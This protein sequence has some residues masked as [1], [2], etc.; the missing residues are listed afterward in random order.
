MSK[1][2]ANIHLP[3]YA[4]RAAKVLQDVLPIYKDGK[5]VKSIIGY[6]TDTYDPDTIL[7]LTACGKIVPKK[8]TL[9]NSTLNMSQTTCERCSDY[10]MEQRATNNSLASFT[11]NPAS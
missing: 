4:W 6:Y 2:I 8:Q 7:V 11:A 9:L 3:L 1:P 5:Q 10:E